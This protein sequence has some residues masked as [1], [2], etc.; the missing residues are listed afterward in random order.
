TKDRCHDQD[1]PTQ[2]GSIEQVIVVHQVTEQEKKQRPDQERRFGGDVLQFMGLVRQVVGIEA[3]DP[4][5]VA[6]RI[7]VPQEKSEKQDEEHR[8]QFVIL[9]YAINENHQQDDGCKFN[10]VMDAVEQVRQQQRGHKTHHEDQQK[11]QP[12]MP[13]RHGIES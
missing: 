4:P 10:G 8:R 7:E 11:L 13:C 5:D 9:G 1:A 3:L 6:I 2:C 12:E